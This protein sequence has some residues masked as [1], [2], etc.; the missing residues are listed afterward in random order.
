MQTD[1]NL[2]A[3]FADVLDGDDTD[4]LPLIRDLEHALPVRRPPDALHA[5]FRGALEARTHGSRTRRRGL[6]HALALR[7]FR[8]HHSLG[9]VFVLLLAVVL[10]G[11]VAYAATSLI[12]VQPPEQR[13][14]GERGTAVFGMFFPPPGYA[15]YRPIDPRRAARESGFAVAYL[16]PPPAGLDRSVGVWFPV[17][18]HLSVP[19]PRPMPG[20]EGISM[21]IRSVVQY[22]QGSHHLLVAL[23]EPSPRLAQQPLLLGQ[24]TIHLANGRPAWSS[25]LPESSQSNTVATVMGGYVVVLAGDVPM[26]IVERLAGT[27]VVVPPAGDPAT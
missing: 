18:R 2:L 1:E 9:L 13:D 8:P 26:K 21:A 4:L 15:R 6:V 23:D 27:V 7:T 16:R 22:H 20:L 24:H 3:A 12:R 10:V 19:T 11:T 25:V 17:P 14:A 5:R